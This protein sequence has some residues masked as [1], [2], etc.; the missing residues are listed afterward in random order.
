ML[1]E[2]STINGN[3]I[4]YQIDT[5]SSQSG[6]PVLNQNNEIIAIHTLGFIDNNDQYTRNSARLILQ[7]SLDTIAFAKGETKSSDVVA[8]RWMVELPV[9]RFYHPGVKR[10][11]YTQ[12]PVEIAHL[13]KIGWKNEGTAFYTK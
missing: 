2:I 5:E 13:K 4:S 9:Y 6:S 10:H 1:G 7:D 3:L 11:H 8:S 12:D